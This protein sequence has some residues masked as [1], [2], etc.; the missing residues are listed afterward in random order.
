MKGE[1][2]IRPVTPRGRDIRLWL[3][4][5]AKESPGG[6]GGWEVIERPKRKSM[7][8]WKG[9]G[10]YSLEISCMLDGFRTNLSVENDL[11]HL[12]QLM[13]S[14]KAANAGRPTIVKVIGPIPMTQLQYV[15]SNIDYGGTIRRSSDGAR[16]RQILSLTLLEFVPADVAIAK[17][18]PAKAT[19]EKKKTSASPTKSTKIHTVKKGDTLWVIAQQY[20]GSGAKWQQ[21]ANLNG[22]RD[23]KKL[24]IGTKLRI[25]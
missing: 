9:Y 11:E 20:L 16:I 15:V 19:Q 1:I 23:P 12:R 2:I 14:P 17:K 25:P 10:P 5:P 13:R 7:T 4:D 6:G 8:S 18:S 22:I 3:G 21:I 24:K